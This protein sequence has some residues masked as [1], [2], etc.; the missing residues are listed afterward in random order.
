MPITYPDMNP[1]RDLARKVAEA[2]V[3]QIPVLGDTA[4]AVWSVTH[5]TEAQSRWEAW[6]KD[7]TKT[8]NDLEAIISELVP[9]ITLSDDAAALG[10]W[11]S[12]V[13]SQGRPEPIPFEALRAAFP[14]ATRRELEDACGEL[15]AVGLLQTSGAIGHV[16][17]YLS[18][19]VELFAVFDPI[20][21]GFDPR[22]DAAELATRILSPDHPPMADELVEALGW[23][24]RRFNPAMQI[25]AG[26][27]ASGRRSGEINAEYA[28]RYV[29]PSPVERARL[30]AFATSVLME[31]R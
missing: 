5:P 26:F 10:V 12:K 21:V 7:V 19:T 4:V 17:A 22:R 31:P 23:T 3:A 6:S 25:V 30:T 20:A 27:V 16:I 9:T 18:P 2:L 24:T 1:K 13:S 15:E 11:A 14:G 29:M 28:C 8:I